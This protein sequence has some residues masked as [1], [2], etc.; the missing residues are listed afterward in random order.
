[1]WGWVVRANDTVF[2]GSASG[3]AEVLYSFDPWF[4]VFPGDLR[5]TG[6]RIWELG[7]LEE[8]PAHPGLRRVWDHFRDQR[9]RWLG[10]RLP[11]ELTGGRVVYTSATWIRVQELPHG[12]VADS[13]VPIFV[14]DDGFTMVAVSAD[15][16]AELVEIWRSLPV[17]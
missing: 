13:L 17:R 8:A 10:A 11:F 15:W 2:S 3:P 1:V 12:R 4:E 14:D 5:T 6:A 9:T 16:P 7:L